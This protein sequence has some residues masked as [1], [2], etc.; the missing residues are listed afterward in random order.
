MRR[1]TIVR[2]GGAVAAL[3]VATIGL[4]PSAS[5]DAPFAY[6]W[7]SAT[8]LG[9]LPTAGG[10]LPDVLG[11]IAVATPDVPAD[12]M[13]VQ[14][15]ALG[16]IAFAALVYDL[17]PDGA[18]AQ[19]VLPVAEGTTVV[20]GTTLRLCPLSEPDIRPDVGGPMADAPA[21]DCSTEVTGTANP[22]GTAFAFD[23]AELLVEGVL[24]VAL[25]PSLPADRVVFAKPGDDTLLAEGAAPIEAPTS[26]TLPPSLAVPSAGGGGGGGTSFSPP[27]FSPNLPLPAAPV[28]AAAPATPAATPVAPAGF[29]APLPAAAAKPFLVLLLAGALLVAGGLWH[30]SGAAG[31]PST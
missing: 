23:V 6:G 9:P 24:A 27:V 1:S 28:G 5:A 10:A 7:W 18:A 8:N 31:A 22:E 12:G 21:Y 25:L 2:R 20:P 29:P 26:T 3:L 4:G 11:P 16:P 15:G 19:L 17:G 13:L 14:G 30:R